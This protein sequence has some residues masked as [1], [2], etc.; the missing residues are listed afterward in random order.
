MPTKTLLAGVSA[1]ALVIGA[2]PAFAADQDQASASDQS[3]RQAQDSATVT[4][5]V[6]TATGRSEKVM[7]VPLAM[8]V[9]TGQAL[10]KANVTS[11]ESVK[12]IEPA[13]N[14][15]TYAAGVSSFVIRGIVSQA[16]PTTG[17]YYGEAPLLGGHQTE[18]SGDPT[19]SLRLVD[20]DRLEVLKGPQG[21][22][23]GA[24][25]MAGTIRAIPAAP[26]T[27]EFFGSASASAGA[28]K[29]GNAL[30][31][32]N[33]ML[34][35]PLDETFAIRAVGW[36]EKGGGFIDHTVAGVG[37]R[38][39]DSNDSRVRGGRLS[40]LWSPTDKFDL[41]AKH[42]AQGIRA[43]DGF[44]ATAGAGKYQNTEVT[45]APYRD[46]LQITDLTAHLR[47]L[48]GT[49]MGV[50]AYTD[51]HRRRT[52]DTSDAA[53]AALGL[54]LPV[55]FSQNVATVAKTAELRYT[56]DW[57]GPF[58][59]VTGAYF[60]RDNTSIDGITVVTD[61]VS[62]LA[63]CLS[64]QSCLQAGSI[65]AGSGDRPGD[66]LYGTTRGHHTRQQAYYA[67]GEYKITETFKATAG[68]RY[69]K[70][71]LE[72]QARNDHTIPNYFKRVVAPGATRDLT[73]ATQSR[74]SYNFSLAWE[75]TTDFTA[76]VRAA[77]GFRI[78]GLNDADDAAQFGVTIPRSYDA[79]SLWNYELGAKAALFDRRLLLDGS[80]FK[81]DWSNQ[82]LPASDPA[83]TVIYTVNAGA[84][85]VKGFELTVRSQ[86]VDGL[87]VDAGVTYVDAKL[88]ADL[89]K[90]VIDGGNPGFQGDRIPNQPRWSANLQTEYS[91]DVASN[92]QGYVGG[93][94]S[95]KGKFGNRF[96]SDPNLA[97]VPAA[98]IVG[99]KLGVRSEGTDIG[100]TVDNLFNKYALDSIDQA[101]F[102]SGFPDRVYV[103]RPR[104]ISIRVNQRF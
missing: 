77:S 28:T 56:S 84:T 25:S 15:R 88:G 62:G 43:K 2:G 3:K 48:G 53:F 85:E 37:K 50:A 97:V 93:D 90:A 70:A 32:G 87:S 12:R 11:L 55:L 7:D 51:F 40:A 80:I 102:G 6:V 54:P 41:T 65:S 72:D 82:Q 14:V 4:E 52:I 96:K 104:T 5:I 20:M 35:V 64:F 38:Y 63:P 89:P 74:V 79:D 30:Y 60:Q 101:V 19:P 9:T 45:V 16:Q 47:A 100:L 26:K 22:L 95:Y 24:G 83:G 46:K 10:E 31:S 67:Q 86:P 91:F 21:T 68:I 99:A 78:G 23:F 39:E 81:I 58:Q 36:A 17:V 13:L 66:V 73:P 27:S 75:P 98:T 71:K 49:F 29:G 61:S 94:V 8:S 92:W 42:T 34:N 76:Y 44:A 59:L 33:L 69:F 57:S 103:G 18:A 1:I